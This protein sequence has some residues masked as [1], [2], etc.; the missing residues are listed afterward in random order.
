MSEDL[1][2]SSALIESNTNIFF[3]QQKKIVGS[4]KFRKLVPPDN[5]GS[6]GGGDLVCN[7]LLTDMLNIDI[8]DAI[9]DCIS[10]PPIRRHQR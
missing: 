10:E 9:R 6:R 1:Q 8:Q 7:P 5:Q 2:E 3:S 4:D